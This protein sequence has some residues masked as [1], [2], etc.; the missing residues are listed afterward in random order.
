[1]IFDICDSE[2]EEIKE[3]KRGKQEILGKQNKVCHVVKVILKNVMWFE[4]TLKNRIVCKQCEQKNY[5][6]QH[7]MN[8]NE[9]QMIEDQ[10][11]FVG[12]FY[13]N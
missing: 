7:G 5:I 4:I 3:L 11:H 1:M 6:Q 10:W 9:H 2:F 12:I 8:A 13:M